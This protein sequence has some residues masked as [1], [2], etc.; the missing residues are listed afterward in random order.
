MKPTLVIAIVAVVLG[1]FL[2]LFSGGKR[3]PLSEIISIKDERYWGDGKPP[4]K[5]T[6][7]K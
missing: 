4:S 6:T 2:F 5:V 1:L 3:T 7:N